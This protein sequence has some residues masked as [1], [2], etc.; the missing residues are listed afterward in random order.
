MTLSDPSALLP[1]RLA[2]VFAAMVV[3][4]IRKVIWVSGVVLQ[5]HMPSQ[6]GGD[7]SSFIL[8][9]N[10]RSTAGSLEQ[11]SRTGCQSILA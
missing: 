6:K 2:A 7:F 5:K 11:V 4:I 1:V 10:Y 9:L 3:L 8:M